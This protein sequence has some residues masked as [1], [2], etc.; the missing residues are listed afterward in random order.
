MKQIAA[1]IDRHPCS[2]RP[3][4]LLAGVPSEN[5][6]VFPAGLFIM[7]SWLHM[8]FE[9]YPFLQAAKIHF[10]LRQENVFH[11][12]SWSS[13][14]FLY[15]L[16]ALVGILLARLLLPGKP[17]WHSLIA[18]F[19]TTCS[20]LFISID[21]II[22][23]LYS[24]HFNGFVLNLLLTPGGIE[25]LGGDT[26]TWLGTSMVVMRLL[27]IQIA[28]LGLS[29]IFHFQI[30]R[31]SWQRWALLLLILA[32]I[33]ERLIYG[34]SDIQ[35]YGKV[36]DTARVYPFYMTSTFRS[37]A[38]KLGIE[39]KGKDTF[40]A[41]LDTSRLQYPLMPVNFRKIE[42]PPNIVWL[43]A[44]S[45]RWDRL[46]PDV[47]P[48]VWE[49]GRK[50]CNFTHHYSSGNGTREGM[51]GMFYGL[52]GSYWSNFL[53]AE[54]SPLLLDRI[55]DL[56][57]QLHFRTS[58][59]FSYPEFDKT[60]FAGIDRQ[61]LHEEEFDGSPWQ[62]DEKNT[63][64]LLDFI[65]NRD[66]NHPF[67]AFMFYESTHARYTFPESARISG[68]ILEQVNYADMS[69]EKLARYADQLLNRYTNASYWVDNQM[70]RIFKVLEQANLLDNTIVI[71]TGDH[72]EEFMEKGF[73]GHN[74]SFVDEQVRTP[75]V[76]RMPG[77]P[78]GTI[79]RPTSH[80]DIPVTLLEQLGIT[81][82]AGD[83]ALGQNLLSEG[84]RDYLVMSDNFSIGLMAAD[85]KYRIPYD[86]KGLTNYQPTGPHDRPFDDER[87]AAL[88]ASNKNLIVEAIGNCSLFTR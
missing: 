76:L 30:A 29:R 62:R 68:P 84:K 21:R 59:R 73:W 57:Y 51:F 45:L 22:F 56:G 15:L 13:Y 78:P 32:M 25:S 49:F 39:A 41:E 27:A 79:D 53:H 16:P 7:F 20:L 23:D 24:F 37:L 8:L 19:L 82:K 44:E 65:R 6:F 69:R 55:Q 18:L 71:V 17:L 66:Q 63:G 34:V 47:M 26:S 74:S 46:T 38:K 50:S 48:H 86:N 81:N 88:I 33:S 52:Y 80:M 70:G 67:M 83:Y 43:V 4:L 31:I 54:Q 28:L 12:L 36:L 1:V 35:N 14:S 64:A 3:V 5:R 85:F 75:L 9:T 11:F 40:T 58:A 60:I 61:F 2:L 42:S 77:L 87:I 72:G 10:S